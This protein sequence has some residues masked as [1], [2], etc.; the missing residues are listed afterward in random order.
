MKSCV[1]ICN[2]AARNAS[3]K[4][5]GLALSYLR[6]KGYRTELLLTAK[7]G[8]ATQLAR[9]SLGYGPDMIVAAGG[10][11]TINEVVNGMVGS[12]VPLSVL[13]LGTT[14]V[15]ARE[16]NIS[17]D[18]YSALGVAV[19]GIPRSV[20]LG[21][22]ESPHSSYSRYFCLMAGIGF[23]GKTVYDLKT[24]FKRFSGKAAYVFGGLR[25]VLFYSPEILRIRIGGSEYEGTNVII[26]KASKYGGEFKVTPDASLTEA[27][28]YT[29]IF[30]G[31]KRRELLRYV[32]GVLRGKHLRDK[33]VV[34]I[35]STDVEISGTA[36]IQIDGDYLGTTP[37]KVSVEKE[38]VKMIW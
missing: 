33:D 35:K 22:I 13:P 12:A 4:K 2:P 6:G 30:K 3:I 37:A 1:I 27:F 9:D 8:H 19:S 31:D 21:R 16:L 32:L 18:L 23:D 15:L 34:Y 11:G 5:V 7:R 26:G 10:D 14:N 28:L 24:G 36:H 29:C 17:C 25:N 20:S 38:A